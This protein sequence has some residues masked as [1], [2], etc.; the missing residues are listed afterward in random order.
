ME[1]YWHR[2]RGRREKKRKGKRE[3][4]KREKERKILEVELQVEWVGFRV[5]WVCWSGW[6][7]G[8]GSQQVAGGL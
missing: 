2:G 6:W 3:K 8:L 7:A 5:R 4:N 1:V